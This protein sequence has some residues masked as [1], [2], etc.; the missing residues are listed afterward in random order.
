MLEDNKRQGKCFVQTIATS[1]IVCVGMD[2]EWKIVVSNKMLP[3]LVAWYHKVTAH[4][5]GQNRL[6][7]TIS[8]HFFHPA[9]H[10]E[11][12]QQLQACDICARHKASSIAYGDLAPQEATCNPW[13]KVQIDSIGPWKIKVKGQAMEF[14]ALTCIEPTTNLIEIICWLGTT[15]AKSWRLFQNAFL[16]CYLHPVRCIHDMGP[17]FKGHD[18]QFG[19]MGAGIGSVPVSLHTPTSNGIIESIHLS[20]GQIIQT[21]IELHP[22]TLRESADHLIDEALSTAMHAC[23]AASTTALS[24]LSPGSVVFHRDM[25]LDIPFVANIVALSNARQAK[26]DQRL[27]RENT[28]RHRHEYRV[29]EQV[30]VHNHHNAS[31]KLKPIFSGPYPILQVHTNN[32]VTLLRDRNVHERMSIRRLKPKLPL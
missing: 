6:K 21:L 29:G 4:V 25:Y 18:F 22:P 28:R 26:I 1:K 27:L 15:A 24:S 13:Y 31:N 20:V 17:E 8:Q 9:L 23:R 10:K 32:T 5:E 3:P 19:L 30:Y 12:T 2:Q 11:I 16:A 14:C 7:T